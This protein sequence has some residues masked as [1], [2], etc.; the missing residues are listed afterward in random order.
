MI[1][2][3]NAYQAPSGQW[4]WVIS[5]DGEDIVRGAGYETKDAALQDMYDELRSRSEEL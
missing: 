2:E 4:S 1:Y 5:G 3:G